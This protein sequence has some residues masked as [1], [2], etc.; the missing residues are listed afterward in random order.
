MKREPERALSSS[1]LFA[2][3][4]KYLDQLKRRSLG[5]DSNI[6]ELP[7][8]KRGRPLLLGS[9]LD[10]RVQLFLKQLRA[11]GAVINTAIVMATAEGIVQSEDSNLLA[12]NGGTIVLSKHWAR[13]IMER[14]N[15]V[16]RR[17]NSKSKVTFTN[18][19]ELREQFLFDIKTIIEFEEIPDDLILNW[20]HT[21][22][23]YIPVS[24]WTMA[25]EGS[26]K[27]EITGI[28]DKSQITV[29]LSVTKAGHYLP[30]QVIYAGKTSRC[31]PKVTFPS[32]WC[33]TCTENHLAN[34][35]TTLTYMDEIPFPYV[36]Q[37]RKEL[38]LPDKQTCLVIFDRFKAQCTKTV[39]EAL[40][41]N[42]ILVAMVPANCTDRLQ[43]L[44]V[45][46][47]KS[48]KEFL[49][50][51]FHHWYASEVSEQLQRKE[52]VKLVDLSLVRVKPLAATWLIRLMDYLKQ[53]PEIAK[54]GFRKAGLL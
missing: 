25:R 42:D 6:N 5:K 7:S 43:P 27:V 39:L 29:V 33:I 45:S 13:S 20:D 1:T 37:K 16:K 3:K 36:K 23:N 54:N 8:K 44:D 30:P 10:E 18:F 51:Q 49:R 34:E 32:G 26:K 50:D 41:E 17:G 24:S 47:N 48:V 46:V 35:V 11:N 4:G 19:E 2:W 53:H 52:D 14:M 21:G 12:K 38:G 22:V 31:L 9:E 40:E 15:F 28:N